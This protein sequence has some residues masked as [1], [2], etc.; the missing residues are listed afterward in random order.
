MYQLSDKIEIMRLFKKGET[1]SQVALTSSIP[2]S[3]LYEWKQESDATIEIKNLI[4]S[5]NIREAK[6][7]IY[8][9]LEN[10]DGDKNVFLSKIIKTLVNNRYLVY[11]E[12]LVEE[13]LSRYPDS[14]VIKSQYVTILILGSN[15]TAAQKLGKEILE[16]EPNNVFIIA[17]LITVSK[18][19]DDWKE[20]ERLCNKRL[21]IEP[22]DKVANFE[23]KSARRKLKKKRKL[24]N[25]AIIEIEEEMLKLGESE[26]EDKINDDFTSQDKIKQVRR[27]IYSGEFNLD[28][29]GARRKE[30]E[31]MGIDELQMNL[32]LAE[33]YNLQNMPTQT[34]ALL[35]RALSQATDSKMQKSI[36]ALMETV[37]I[38]SK[39]PSHINP[40]DALSSQFSNT[41]PKAKS[42]EER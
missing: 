27:Q 1:V 15:L 9:F 8:E 37:R 30:M 32:L 4:N 17:Q 31:D 24:R 29:I 7:K 40:W 41:V 6:K 26:V 19:L 34:A 33:A 12:E 18:K 3:T 35:K 39:K 16:A 42:P 38:K 28:N 10:G 2:I 21:V 14:L 13:A 25:K 22:N 36:K 11:A 20:V 5:G 23:L